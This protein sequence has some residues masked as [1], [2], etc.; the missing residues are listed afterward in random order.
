MAC[1]YLSTI[2][3]LLIVTVFALIFF[4]RAG[5]ARY[6]CQGKCEDIPNCNELCQRVGYQGGKCVPPVS[7]LLLRC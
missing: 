5:M 1:G 2:A 6:V 7:I 4:S 3:K